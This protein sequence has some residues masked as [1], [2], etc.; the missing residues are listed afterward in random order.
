MDSQKEIEAEKWLLPSLAQIS[1][2]GL[3]EA[4]AEAEHS[5]L[6]SIDQKKDLFCESEK[7][8]FNGLSS[9]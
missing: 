9:L 4:E 3:A 6:S 7:L 2:E 1:S 8:K 5:P